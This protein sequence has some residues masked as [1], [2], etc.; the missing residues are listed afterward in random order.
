MKHSK[1]N[2][3]LTESFPEEVDIQLT[4]NFK[5]TV[6]NVLKQ[7]KEITNNEINKTK[8]TTFQQIEHI[9]KESKIIKKE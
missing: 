9:S 3:T 7:L 5:S 8:R 4:K 1:E 2:K 6:L